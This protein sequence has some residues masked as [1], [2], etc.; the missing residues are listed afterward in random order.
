[1]MNN[2]R[3]VAEHSLDSY[4]TTVT[5]VWDSIGLQEQERSRRMEIIL[6]RI[7][8]EFEISLEEEKQFKRNVDEKVDHYFITLRS[9]ENELGVQ[10]YEVRH[11]CIHECCRLLCG[12]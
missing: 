10:C 1:M 8:A 7:M 3:I 5:S 9:L 6:N 2:L 12:C 4:I 11:G